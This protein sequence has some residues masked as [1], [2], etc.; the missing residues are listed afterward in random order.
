MTSTTTHL[1]ETL[2]E[3]GI[4]PVTRAIC[5]IYKTATSGVIYGTREHSKVTCPACNAPEIP[6]CSA[7]GS[8]E[9]GFDDGYSECCN[10]RIEYRKAIV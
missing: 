8:D 7:C 9:P 6:V 1:T 5:G 3:D 10:K 4:F 2:R